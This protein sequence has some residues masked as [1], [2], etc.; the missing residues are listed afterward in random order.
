MCGCLRRVTGVSLRI[1]P[2]DNGRLPILVC[3]PPNLLVKV[4]NRRHKRESFSVSIE[5]ENLVLGTTPKRE[6][7]S[8]S[9]D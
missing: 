8:L 5:T 1:I 2:K 7:M 4:H 6:T 9:L 3:F